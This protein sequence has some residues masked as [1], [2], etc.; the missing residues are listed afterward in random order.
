MEL[1]FKIFSVFIWAVSKTLVVH[2]LKGII[3]VLPSNIEDCNKPLWGSLLN[4][5]CF[6]R[7]FPKAS[8][9]TRRVRGGSRIYP[10]SSQSD[11]LG[12][13]KK[14]RSFF[15]P[16]QARSQKIWIT[17]QGHHLWPCTRTRRYFWGPKLIG[18]TQVS[19]P[20]AVF[21]CTCFNQN[22]T[23]PSRLIIGNHGSFRWLP[24]AKDLAEPSLA[25]C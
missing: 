2:S 1:I 13:P 4:N 15:R 3:P 11:P 20:L 24:L 21:W 16:K 22:D 6:H 5:P 9:L 25:L 12:F 19:C 10:A 23:T 7:V 17:S 8:P 14:T 18:I